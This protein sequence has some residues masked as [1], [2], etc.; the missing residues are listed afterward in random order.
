MGGNR[1]LQEIQK[2]DFDE[3][4]KNVENKNK[5]L[6]R[7]REFKFL[8]GANPF[9]LQL[10]TKIGK[11]TKKFNCLALKFIHSSFYFL[12]TWRRTKYINSV[13]FGTHS[14]VFGS[15][16]VK[17]RTH[18]VIFGKKSSHIDDKSSHD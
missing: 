15:H 18:L 8:A 16:A 2:R 3:I 14:V 1:K 9:K 7:F 13:I 17:F 11:N 4:L 10:G 12:H 5:I 6:T